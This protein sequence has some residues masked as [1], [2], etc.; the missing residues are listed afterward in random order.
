MKQINDKE[1]TYN[2]HAHIKIIPL[3][4]LMDCT[5]DWYSNSQVSFTTNT[6]TNIGYRTIAS[7]L[8]HVYSKPH[9]I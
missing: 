2:Q 6:N 5:L 7:T 4:E 8:F 9:I 3:Y 1:G